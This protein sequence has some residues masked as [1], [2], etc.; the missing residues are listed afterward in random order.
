[1]PD[2]L[3]AV[4][5]GTGHHDAGSDL[6][7]VPSVA[8][9]LDDLAVALEKRCGFPADGITVVRDPASPA[10][11]GAA[12]A[13]AAREAADVLLVHYVGHGILCAD[14]LLHLAAAS[15]SGDPYGVQYTGLPY[16]VLARQIRGSRARHRIVIL[17]CCFSGRA[18]DDDTGLGEPDSETLADQTA[19]TGGFVLTSTSRFVPAIAPEGAR[20]TAFTGALL[21]LLD[22]GDRQGPAGITLRHVHH[23]LSAVLPEN[24]LPQPRCRAD[25]ATGD[26]VIAAN[27][28]WHDDPERSAPTGA[29]APAAASRTCPYKGLAAFDAGDEQWFHG[30]AALTALL[31]RR[32]AERHH[33]TAGPVVVVGASGAGKSSLLRAGLLPALARGDLEAAGSAYWPRHVI[34]PGRT[35]TRALARVLGAGT[36]AQVR[37]SPA[38]LLPRL[39]SKLGDRRMVLV[40]DQFEEVFTAAGPAERAAFVRALTTLAG[41][42]HG[43]AP[44]VLVVI[45]IREDFYGRLTVDPGLSHLVRDSPV[46]V[47]AMSSGEIREAILEPAGRAGLTVQPELVDLLLEDLG[48]GGGRSTYEP[49]RLPLLSHALQ[50]TWQRHDRVMTVEA[51]RGTGGLRQALIR[52]AESVLNEVPEPER[53]IARQLLVRLVLV[54]DR[55]DH[56]RRVLTWAELTAGL[57][58]DACRRIVDLFTGESARLLSADADGVRITHEALISTWPRLHAWVEDDRDGLRARQELI[59]AAAEWRR[60]GDTP[61][62]LYRGHRLAAA[63][64]VA[65]RPGADPLPQSALDFLEAA[66]AAAH[67]RRHVR[68]G[69]LA[70]MVVMTLLAAVTAVVTYRLSESASAG[71]LAAKRQANLLNAELLRAGD[72]RTAISLAA[73]DRSPGARPTLVTA[74]VGSRFR[75]VVAAPGGPRLTSMTTSA[76]GKVMAASDGTSVRLWDIS[77]P[78]EPVALPPFGPPTGVEQVEFAPRGRLLAVASRRTDA[79]GSAGS[80]WDVTDPARPARRGSIGPLVWHNHP[81]TISDLAFNHDG[82][83]LAT[84]RGSVGPQPFATLW[85]VRNP[86]RL[87]RLAQTPY[88]YQSSTIWAVDFSPDGKFLATGSKDNTVALWRIDDCGCPTFQSA[89]AATSTDP[90][91]VRFHP[92]G[93]MLMSG[94]LTTA[95]A[96]DVTDPRRVRPLP[97]LPGNNTTSVRVIA[98]SPDGRTMVMA[99]GS[100]TV[101]VWDVSRPEAPVKLADMADHH[102]PITAVTFA[103]DGRHFYTAGDDGSI[104]LWSTSDVGHPAERHWTSDRLERAYSIGYTDRLLTV[105]TPKGLLVSEVSGTGRPVFRSLIPGAEAGALHHARHRPLLVNVEQ[106]MVTLWDLARPERPVLAAVLTDDAPHGESEISGDGTRLTLTEEDGTVRTWDITDPYLPRPSPAADRTPPPLTLTW[107]RGT[108]K[109]KLWSGGR[110]ADLPLFSSAKMSLNDPVFSPDHRLLAVNDYGTVRI[111]DVTD[112]AAPVERATLVRPDVQASTPIVFSPDG[113]TLASAD[114]DKGISFWDLTE[115]REAILQPYERAARL[116]G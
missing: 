111:F 6:P 33:G 93:D 43:G 29:P 8:T 31:T 40:V 50:A 97:S 48:I 21:R 4:L 79:G 17:D 22:D 5:I 61:D 9:T 110:S 32:L 25:N 52:T 112:P 45:G 86:D 3:R 66:G 98:F 87:V 102:A 89:F 13:A 39:R 42:G 73:S 108:G 99:G 15:T 51:Y 105:E 35:P 103:G 16:R 44:C 27:P 107:D 54:G 104:V 90:V 18:L 85:D 88:G 28:A 55:T 76:D 47:A 77:N 53:D 94:T 30:R 58:Q 14:G 59:T 96:Y 95:V 70:A 60:R 71:Q 113:N 106:S 26:L 74:L 57:P 46:V 11:I 37:D 65:D 41:A 115:L 10:E 83:M 24:D 101:T 81:H 116:T 78:A 63:R 19:L 82:T 91:V 80:L 109:P 56:V 67:R 38:D 62:D 92:S 100:D 84:A 72:S 114:Y 12:V 75:G 49:G 7:D 68:T 36:A 2:G 34:N 64:E 23:Y 20:H 69:A 1:M